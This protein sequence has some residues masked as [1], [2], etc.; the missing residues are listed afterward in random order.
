MLSV[1]VRRVLVT[2]RESY[3]LATI[4]GLIEILGLF[5]KRALQIRALEPYTIGLFLQR[6]LAIQEAY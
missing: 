3:R 4:S 2:I 1:L 6:D 5:C